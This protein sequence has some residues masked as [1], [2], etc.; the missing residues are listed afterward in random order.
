MSKKTFNPSEMSSRTRSI[1][2]AKANPRAAKGRISTYLNRDDL[3]LPDDTIARF[4]A[5]GWTLRWIRHTMG[6]GGQFDLKNVGNRAKMGYVPVVAEEVP[7]IAMMMMRRDVALPG[8][9]GAYDFKDVIIQGDL[10]LAKCPTENVKAYRREVFEETQLR[11]AAVSRKAK[12]DGLD[13]DESETYST[14]GGRR[15]YVQR[16]N[17]G[18]AGDDQE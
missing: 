1:D 7:E 15:T 14:Q 11:N 13:I 6:V 8:A 4:A 9:P 5:D 17:I 12:R 16:Q 2:V 10:M 18:F 3:T